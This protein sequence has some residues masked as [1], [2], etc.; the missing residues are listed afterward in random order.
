MDSGGFQLGQGNTN[1][2]AALS[3]ATKSFINGNG[4]PITPPG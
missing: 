3:T 1:T 4:P 2:F